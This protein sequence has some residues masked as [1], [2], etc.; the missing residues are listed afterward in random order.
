MNYIMLRFLEERLLLTAFFQISNY[1]AE[2]HWYLHCISYSSYQ[3]STGQILKHSITSYVF[4][5]ND[6]ILNIW[7]RSKAALKRK[8][9]TLRGPLTYRTQRL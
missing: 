2:K 8:Q 4:G 1:R 6:A 3:R 9:N 5:L 7:M